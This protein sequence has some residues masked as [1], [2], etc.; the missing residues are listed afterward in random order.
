MAPVDPKV[1]TGAGDGDQ[2]IVGRL[3]RHVTQADLQTGF[4]F[5]VTHQPVRCSQRE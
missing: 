2:A 1:V 5:L 3:Q 4:A